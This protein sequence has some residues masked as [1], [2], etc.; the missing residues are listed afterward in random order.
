MAKTITGI[1]A[2]PGIRIGKA[3]LLGKS[4]LDVPKYSIDEDSIE[5]ETARLR[6]AVAITKKDLLIINKQINISLSKEISDI[7]ESHLMI[8]D[9][10]IIVKKVGDLISQE[11]KNA[12]WAVDEIS[13]ELIRNLDSGGDE[14]LQDRIIDISDL[15]R[16]II[17]NLQETINKMLSEIDEEVILFASNLSPA[18]IATMNKEMVLALVTDKGG[19]TSHTSIIARALGIPAIVGTNDCTSYIKTG[20]SVIVDALEGKI[21]INPDKNTVKEYKDLKSNYSKRIEELAKLA[22]LPSKTTD[23]IQVNIF[24]NIEFPDEMKIIK[25]YGAQGIG[26][27]RS[28]FLFMDKSLPDEE[29]QFKSYSDIVKYFFPQPVTIRTLDVGGDKILGFINQNKEKNPFLGCRA[30]RFSLEHENLFKIQIRAILKASH[31]GNAKLLFPLITCLSELNKAKEITYGIMDE[32]KK[33]GIPFNESIP[34]GIMIEVPSA[35]I[36]SDVLAKNC[37]F[38]SVGTN[39]L[40]Q[41]MSAVDRVNEKLAYL[42][43]PVDISMLRILKLIRESAQAENIPVS[44]CGEMVAHPEY[45]A[46]LLGL[47]Y[48]DFSMSPIYMHQIKQIIRNVNMKECSEFAN[49]ILECSDNCIIQEKLKEKYT[50]K[51]SEIQ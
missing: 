36:K 1:V 13:N 4:A 39:D 5:K 45:T 11:K 18:E 3:F 27:L 51:I 41:Y 20:D 46:L 34:I 49:E 25:G 24:G 33:E 17:A 15:N 35:A 23:S 8:L 14:Y 38:F 12:E 40:I 7:F 31:Y 6:K 48:T 37:D 50:K 47:G 44:I 42:Y 16:R 19:P 29:T 21:I 43:N 2:S 30:I 32:L 9:D 26:L 28:E 22:D 10:P